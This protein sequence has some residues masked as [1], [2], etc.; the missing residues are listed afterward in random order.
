MVS[1]VAALT[2]GVAVSHVHH[3]G[4]LDLAVHH[5]AR[6]LSSILVRNKVHLDHYKLRHASPSGGCVT[7]PMQLQAK[8]CSSEHP[9]LALAWLCVWCWWSSFGLCVYWNLM[10]HGACRI[11]LAVPTATHAVSAQVI[12][13]KQCV[14]NQSCGFCFL[15][16]AWFSTATITIFLMVHMRLFSAQEGHG[17]AMANRGLAGPLPL[18]RGRHKVSNAQVSSLQSGPSTPTSCLP[19]LEGSYRPQ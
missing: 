14:Q 10:M 6:F 4:V 16:I 13:T 18:Q 5:W 12:Q 7:R 2:S 1:I 9:M 19:A 11:A 3:V 17:I 8:S 15:S